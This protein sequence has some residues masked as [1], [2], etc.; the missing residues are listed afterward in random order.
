MLAELLS[1]AHI[2]NVFDRRS[3][4]YRIDQIVRLWPAGAL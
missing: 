1:V 3:A 4:T 2:G